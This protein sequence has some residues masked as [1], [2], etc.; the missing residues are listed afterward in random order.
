MFH[1]ATLSGHG[2]PLPTSSDLSLIDPLEPD[3]STDVRM[4]VTSRGLVRLALVASEAGARFQREGGGTD[5]MAWMLAPRRLFAGSAAIEA[6]LE[7]EAC[8][9]AVLV[10]GLGLGVDAEAA[11]I[12]ELLSDDADEDGPPVDGG[13]STD[14]EPRLFTATLSE[15]VGSGIVQSFDAAV[16]GSEADM[17][18]RMRGRL[19]DR[20]AE[21]ASVVE[22][23]PAG[24][25]LSDALVSDAVADMLRLVA[26]D[27]G[28]SL[29]AGLDVVIEQRFSS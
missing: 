18:A 29:A 9:R 8:L 4:S 16:V 17:R 25:P 12:D 19:G 24:T 11:D 21:A 26:A 5:P 28:S 27:P 14:S 1:D 7:R 3:G 13:A 6:C 20:L 2:R 15:E 10:H 22:G 23:F